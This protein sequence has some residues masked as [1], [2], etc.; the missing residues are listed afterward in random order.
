M[1]DP[2]GGLTAERYGHP[3]NAWCVSQVR[4][5]SRIFDARDRNPEL[6]EFNHDISDWDVSNGLDFFAMFR[7]AKRFNQDLSRWNMAKAVTTRG[8]V[9]HEA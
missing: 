3:I 2:T 5:F 9:S 6:E 7:H 8:M 1:Q 4:D